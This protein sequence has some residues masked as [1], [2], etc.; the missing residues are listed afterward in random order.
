M[1]KTEGGS[2]QGKPRVGNPVIS[3]WPP[4]LNGDLSQLLAE[5]GRR[6]SGW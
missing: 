1:R 4:S 5:I 6:C 2:Y 3:T